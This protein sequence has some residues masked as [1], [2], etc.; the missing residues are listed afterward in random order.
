MNFSYPFYDTNSPYYES[1]K[2][3]SALE[4]SKAGSFT[5]GG[6]G[7]WHGGVHFESSAGIPEDRAIR[8]I[9]DGEV[10][11]YRL[12]KEY[13]K[14]D[15]E[16]QDGTEYEYST[17][18][19]LIKHSYQS[20]FGVDAQGTQT[21]N[22]NELEFYSLY[23]HLKPFN[24]YE[25][26]ELTALPYCESE[27]QYK[28]SDTADDGENGGLNM[29]SV[30]SSS[31]N[32][33]LTQLPVGTKV[34]ISERG[35]TNNNW[36]HVSEIVSGYGDYEGG[37]GWIYL[38]DADTIE[39]SVPNKFDAFRPLS[40]YVTIKAGKKIGF[41]GKYDAPASSTNG[42]KQLHLEIFTTATEAEITAF[43]SNDA[44]VNLP[45]SH[46]LYNI[47]QNASF[48]SMQ[49]E[50]AAEGAE[51]PAPTFADFTNPQETHF[52]NVLINSS[53]LK[54]KLE[55]DSSGNK[56]LPL[57]AST[58]ATD[59]KESAQTSEGWVKVIG[60]DPS[61]WPGFDNPPLDATADGVGY[62]KRDEP[63]TL[64]ATLL[65]R[66]EPSYVSGTETPKV[67]ASYVSAAK[68]MIAKDAVARSIIKHKVE[69]SSTY[70]ADLMTVVT[71]EELIPDAEK[72]TRFQERKEELDFWDEVTGVGTSEA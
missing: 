18:F 10:V 7:F 69:W 6:N 30:P 53:K 41:M 70:T 21:Q 48:K 44:D 15:A 5:L 22:R 40:P 68:Q 12:N 42:R 13:L 72:R 35:G 36:G 24:E 64:M 27:T 38:N 1:K 19:V 3:W 50:E 11:A 52:Q 59:N 23:M 20:L 26:D 62:Y 25:D 46:D 31:G 16:T 71:S 57:S 45:E 37:L 56:W 63:S 47:V 4:Q 49:Q 61:I 43:L 32:T 17:S 14:K 67:R 65:K 66:V 58:H 9:A 34:K 28:V 55:T 8:A 60:A 51:A 29:R 54:S 2:L 33:P 39:L